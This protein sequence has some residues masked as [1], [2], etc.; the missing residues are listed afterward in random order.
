MTFYNE[1]RRCFREHNPLDHY[2]DI[3]TIL[4][5]FETDA[6]SF[7]PKTLQEKHNKFDFVIL[8]KVLELY[9]RKKTDTVVRKYKFDT[10]HPLALDKFVKL[11]TKDYAY[12]YGDGGECKKF[13]R[14]TKPVLI[15]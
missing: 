10:P 9:E 7:D 4:L 5:G 3:D 13:K 11:R 15:K 14:N 8:E 2:M 6:L 1:L 12:L